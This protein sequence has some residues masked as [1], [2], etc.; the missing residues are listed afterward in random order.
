M[1]RQACI[2]MLPAAQHVTLQVW[3][4]QTSNR[5]FV[6]WQIKPWQ[7]ACARLPTLK[8]VEAGVGAAMLLMAPPSPLLE[9]ATSAVAAGL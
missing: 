6:Q 2:L 1:P 4:L 7:G 9:L 5:H 8:D 3:G